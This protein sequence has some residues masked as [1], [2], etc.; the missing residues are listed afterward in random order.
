MKRKIEVTAIIFKVYINLLVAIMKL[1]L[2]KVG[3]GINVNDYVLYC[4]RCCGS[5][6]SLTKILMGLFVKI[7]KW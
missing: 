1:I 4:C 3:I 2:W 7:I 5:K 6:I